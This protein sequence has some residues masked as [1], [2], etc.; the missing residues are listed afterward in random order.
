MKYLYSTVL[1]II[2]LFVLTTVIDFNYVQEVENVDMD[3]NNISKIV[4]D[5][6][7][8]NVSLSSTVDK[9]I[10]IEHLYSQSQYETSNLYTYQEGDIL[11]VNEYPYNKTNLITKKETINI[12]IPEEYEFDE[13]DVTT[14]SGEINVDSLKTGIFKVMS[15]TGNIDIANLNANKIGISGDQ[16][17]VNVSNIV[18]KEFNASIAKSQ[19][20][21]SNSIV[22]SLKVENAQTSKVNVSKLVAEDVTVVG[23]NTDVN[24]KLNEGIGYKI[25]SNLQIGNPRLTVEDDGYS[26]LENN[27]KKATTYNLKDVQSVSIN[28]ETLAEDTDE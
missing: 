23:E 18:A 11:Y 22:N 4:V 14:E 15:N 21:I 16:L 2:F 3:G 5:I 10:K 26:Y 17:G 13:I 27:L 12:Y 6:D 7:D 19:F 1:F 9:D 24:L 20:T 25:I 8:A 28:F